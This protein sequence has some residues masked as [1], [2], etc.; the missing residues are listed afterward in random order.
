MTLTP[1]G[2]LIGG[3]IPSLAAPAGSAAFAMGGLALG[4]LVVAAL[5]IVLGRRGRAR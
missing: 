1:L 3:G 5:V 4:L 2:G